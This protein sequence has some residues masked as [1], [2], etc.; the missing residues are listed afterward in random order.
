M[1]IPRLSLKML[2]WLHEAK[3]NLSKLI[4]TSLHA[5][6]AYELPQIHKDPLLTE[7]FW[8]RPRP[9]ASGNIHSKGVTPGYELIEKLRCGHNR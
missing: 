5:L 1:K 4:N 8:H 6:A 9:K 2:F 7:C 3:T